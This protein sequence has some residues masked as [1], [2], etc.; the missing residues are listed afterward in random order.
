MTRSQTRVT[1]SLIPQGTRITRSQIP[2]NQPQVIITQQSPRIRQES[3]NSSRNSTPGTNSSRTIS[4]IPSPIGSGGNSR[5]YTRSISRTSSVGPQLVPEWIANSGLVI[6]GE[7]NGFRLQI[8]FSLIHKL[9]WITQ[10]TA[11]RCGIAG[12]QLHGDYYLERTYMGHRYNQRSRNNVNIKIGE[13]PNGNDILITTNDIVPIVRDD[14]FYY[15]SQSLQ[16]PRSRLFFLIG[17]DTIQQNN[18]QIKVNERGGEIFIPNPD[19]Q[20]AIGKRYYKIKAME[21]PDLSNQSNRA[22]NIHNVNKD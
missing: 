7:I 15:R 2:Q 20:P 8:I 18:I 21:Y 1:R 22:F 3:Q 19:Y 5:S 9:D 13:D 17:K 6:N 14:N 10:E 4:R 12:I 11:R 16:D